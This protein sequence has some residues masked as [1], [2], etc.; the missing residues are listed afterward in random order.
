MRRSFAAVGTGIIVAALPV[1]CLTG[2]AK[3]PE[4]EIIDAVSPLPS[5]QQAGAAVR[6]YRNGT[7]TE[8]RAGTNG[9]IC[10]ADDPARE[11][12]HAACYHQSLEPFMERG[13]AL[14]A[15]GL[16]AEAADSVRLAELEAKTLAL[17]R[18]G[19]F[20]Y[21]IFADDAFDPTD[22]VP[23]GTRGLYVLYLPYATEASTGIPATPSRERPWLMFPGLPTAHVMIPR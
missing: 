4:R 5:G 23:D 22:G 2:Q 7:L 18:A 9:L 20:L 1:A 6:A 8:I 21:S 19:A 14:R 3:S 17:P 10:L 12:F 15:S 16:T 11:G 13:R